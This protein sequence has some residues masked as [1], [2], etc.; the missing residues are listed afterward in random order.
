ML[1]ICLLSSS[2]ALGQT[3]SSPPSTTTT[4]T[5]YGTDS[6]KIVSTGATNGTY[7]GMQ[8]ANG[9]SPNTT[10]STTTTNQT[11]YDGKRLDG[12]EGRFGVY[13]GVNGS[14]F[15]N[16]PIPDNSY[17]PGYQVGLYYRSPGTVFGQIGAEY[18]AAS[19]NL[20]RSDASSGT[21]SNQLKDHIDQQFLAIPAYV[22]IR[23]GG[24]LGFRI[25]AGAELA[26]LVAVGPNNFKLGK[27]DL[28]RTILNGLG[29]IGINLGP[30]TLDAAY[31]HGFVQVFDKGA[32]TKRNILALNVGLRF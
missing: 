9:M 1:A 31:N 16:E 4:T 21:V 28:N 22:G 3:P 17:R 2:I 25:Q 29:G 27:D 19:A 5:T 30:I 13:V 7:L 23:L 12:K 10:Y 8:S 14:Q 26:A 6:S 20:V 18:R 32:D 24:S 11:G 15:V